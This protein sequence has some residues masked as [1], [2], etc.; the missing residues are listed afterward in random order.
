MGLSLDKAQPAQEEQTDI[1]EDIQ[2]LAE[3]RFEAKKRKDF[4]QADALRAKLTELGYS[5]LDSKDGFKIVLI[6]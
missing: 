4:A 5:V 1:P 6:K 3:E 2:K